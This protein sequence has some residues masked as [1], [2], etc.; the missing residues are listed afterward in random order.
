MNCPLDQR[1]I[2]V[3]TQLFGQKGY[4]STSVREVVEAVGVTK[5]TLYYHF[6][7]KEGLFLAT[8]QAHLESIDQLVQDSLASG[9][10]LVD[11]LESLLDANIRYASERPDVVRFL[12][13][14]LH[15][16]DH[17]Q[18]EID[19]MSVDA[20]TVRHLGA[21]FYDAL[22]AGEL[23]SGI[24]VPVACISFLGILRGWSVGAF[25][26]APLPPDVARIAVHHFLHGIRP[27]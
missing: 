8:A 6:G 21:V 11:K 5:P 10:T 18:P 9:E 15:Q 23:D 25:H 4:G 7:S 12:A 14:C 22:D 20:T 19:L 3:A 26:G 2:D 27:R 16:V 1:I 13:T 24:N 17:G